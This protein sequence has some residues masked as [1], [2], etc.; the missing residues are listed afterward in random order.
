MA[1][2]GKHIKRYKEIPGRLVQ[3]LEDSSFDSWIDLYHPYEESRNSSIS[4]YLKGELV[5]LCL[6]LEIR[7]KTGNAK[8]LD[9]VMRHFWTEFGSKGV[10]IPDE[11]YLEEAKKVT[12]LD[13][14][15][16][17]R[18]YVSGTKEIDFPVFL[19]Y[20]GLDLTTEDKDEKKD[21]NGKSPGKG[22]DEPDDERP[23]YMGVET[24]RTNG[25]PKIT[26]VLEGSPAHRGGLSA[27]DEIVAING[28][29]VTST[30]LVDTLKRYDPGNSIDVTIFR[31]AR[32]ATIPV[33]LGKPPP[34][35]WTVKPRS[36]LT[37]EQKR[38]YE[39]WLETSLEGATK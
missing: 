35:K 21:D 16:F 31:R 9:D 3:S 37:D 25:T 10:G 15:D 17:F 8:S 29:R 11:S 13:L 30:N 32:L 6:D 39:S 23:A 20:A 36:A 18:D 26:L 34:E 12:G 33:T 22:D 19:G 2:V 38:I 14:T 5:S 27:G 28:T 7:G 1:A 24:E 4:Y